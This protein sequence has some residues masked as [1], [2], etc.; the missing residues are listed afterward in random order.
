M[1]EQTPG[2]EWSGRDD[3]KV[4]VGDT[5]RL[6]QIVKSDIGID[7][8]VSGSVGIIGFQ[9]DEGVRR[10]KGRPGAV[11]GPIVL[12][13]ALANLP[14]YDMQ[15]LYDFGNV[16]VET[17]LEEG[18]ELLGEKVASLLEK[19]VFPVVLGGGHEVAFGTF[20]GLNHFLEQTDPR[21]ERN[22]VILN[23][24]AHFDV[25]ASRPASSGTPFDQIFQAIQRPY[26]Y[27]NSF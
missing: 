27:V 17:E 20:L 16:K 12:R 2:V 21:R 13:E 1:F 4:E 9:S 5:W 8:A 18:Q 14:A 11:D 26:Q 15:E 6:F 3:S 23:L 25:R 10:N 22:L 24:D 19:G 7:S